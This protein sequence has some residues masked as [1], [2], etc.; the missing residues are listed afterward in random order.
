LGKF[1]SKIRYSLIVT[2]ETP[3]VDED[4]YTAIKT[5]IESKTLVKTTIEAL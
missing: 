1:N 3:E 2:I 4:L 5:K